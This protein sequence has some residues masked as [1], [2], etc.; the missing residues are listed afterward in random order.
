MR[1]SLAYKIVSTRAEFQFS[2]RKLKFASIL[3]LE[4][5]CKFLF[6]PEDSLL[7]TNS[8]QISKTASTANTKL[9]C[10]LGT[11]TLAMRMLKEN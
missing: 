10:V 11:R 4:M 2:M 7:K 6:H 9:I 5:S 8:A 1:T 3:T